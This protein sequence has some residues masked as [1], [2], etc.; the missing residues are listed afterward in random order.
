MNKLGITLNE[1]EVL[2]GKQVDLNNWKSS[3]C[4]AGIDA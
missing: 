1:P 3:L 4:K 2:Y